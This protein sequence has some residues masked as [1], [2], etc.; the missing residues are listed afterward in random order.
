MGVFWQ[1]VKYG[2][3][4]LAKSPGLTAAAVLSLAL[5]IGANSTV[6]TW[7][8]AF[9]FQPL[10][11]VVEQGRI[12]SF[13][14]SWQNGKECCGSVSY[15]DYRDYRDRN[16]TLEGLLVADAE[17]VSLTH[18]GRAERAW[19]QL[20]SGNYFDVLRL[21]PT[22][23]RF[24]LPEEDRTPGTHPVVVLAYHYWQRRFGGDI[25]ILNQN[26]TINQQPYTVVGVGPEGFQGT[27]VAF[28]LDIFIPVMMTTSVKGSDRLEA[29]DSHWLYML[30]RTKPGV[31]IEQVQTDFARMSADLGREY[32]KSN[33]GKGS[34][35]DPLW[36]AKNGATEHM[37]P[38]MGILMGVVALVLLIACA[39]VANLLLA[40]AVGRRRE[41]AIRLSLGA[42]R[43]RLLRQLLTES[44]LLAVAAGAGGLLLAY[45]TKNLF[46]Y[47]APVTDVPVVLP[48]EVNTQVLLF[49][50]AIS[51]ATGLLFGLAPAL[52]ATRADV[53]PALKDE[54]AGAG[55]ARGKSRL[56]G[57]L[58]VAQVSLSLVLLITASLFLQSLLNTQTTNPGFDKNL[59]LAGM[60]L[61]PSG[62]T[63]ERGR[64]FYEQLLERVRALPGVE[65]ATLGRFIPLGLSGTS[66]TTIQVD[67]YEP[68]PDE[69]PFV[70]FNH[71]GPDYF[72]TMGIPILSG[73]EFTTAD[74]ADAQSVCI[75]NEATMR[76]YF[77]GTDPIGRTVKIG[78]VSLTVIGVARDTK[79]RSL[80]ERPRVQMWLPVLQ[81]YRPD[82]YLH[83]RAAGDPA[84]LAPAVQ[85]A[86][87]SL[88][89]TLPLFGIRTM[90]THIEAG[91]IVQRTGGTML[92]I[93]GTLALVLAAVGLYGVIAYIFSQ[94][95]REMG[96]RV[97]LGAGRRDILRLVIAHGAW[98]AGI[99]LVIGLG[100]SVMLM[101][102][103][104]SQLVGVGGRDFMTFASTALTLA[105][106][107][108]AAS[109]IPARRA[110][111]VDPI[112][113]LRYE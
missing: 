44:M 113:A 32:V 45:W 94:R 6:F 13:S 22:A 52:Q 104:E 35:V 50:G 11:G 105:A 48:F 75:V 68:A 62:Y 46:M 21:R 43:G 109:Y 65:S 28:Q 53:V 72:R 47:L 49:T 42:G 81:R 74:R 3:R 56:R 98:L 66:S 112:V 61:F 17:G 33:E 64:V 18:D 19:A 110:A 30:G 31:N 5:G 82:I 29:R 59:L 67:G 23:G 84:A 88:D 79:M 20:V 97:A 34:V 70:Y 95:T 76:R 100:A 1:D 37:G 54:S 101:P 106:V 60:D 24:F 80:T 27:M 92:G 12:V 107:A 93:F 14:T 58:V 8:Q 85:E 26:V 91:A 2:M 16:T 96:I 89:P 86:V 57:A 77:G 10:P 103:L 36:R 78:T 15:P 55:G 38:M 71:I 41:I 25:G 9:M 40:R 4:A 102:L 83:T 111:K 51:L 108:L 99:G 90:T 87:R 7:A 69:S 39:N 63:P 73:R